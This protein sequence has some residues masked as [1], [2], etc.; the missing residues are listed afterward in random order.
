[1]LRHATG[2]VT[3]IKIFN[4]LKKIF[5]KIYN[6]SLFDFRLVVWMKLINFPT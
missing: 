5:S 6:L 1:M 2:L 4:D 3:H